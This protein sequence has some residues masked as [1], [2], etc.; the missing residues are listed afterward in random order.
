M[1][2]RQKDPEHPWGWQNGGLL[3]TVRTALSIIHDLSISISTGKN[4]GAP[5]RREPKIEA[6]MF[7][8]CSLWTEHC[9]SCWNRAMDKIIPIFAPMGL[10]V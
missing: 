4:S 2:E 10:T 7:T 6:K 8:E 1:G 5:P 3:G 9:A